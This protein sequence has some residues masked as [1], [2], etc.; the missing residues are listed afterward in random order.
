MPT[1]PRTCPD[2]L[3]V[4]AGSAGS[5]KR[6]Q[7]GTG[8]RVGRWLRRLTASING[9]E[10]SMGHDVPE[11]TDERALLT[12]A[13]DAARHAVV[14]TLVGVPG[15]LLGEPLVSPDSSLLGV[16][17]HLTLLERRWFAHTF[18]GLDLALEDTDGRRHIGWPLDRS[19]TARTVVAEYRAECQRSR[20]IV[21]RARLDQVAARPMPSG[22]PVALRWVVVD[23]IGE[24]NR[25]AGHADVLRHLI[26]GATGASAAP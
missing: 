15:A 5:R 13:L 23:M 14:S 1:M 2:D 18:A 10:V 17:K 12:A 26:D 3:K 16:V 21:E 9:R 20:Q 19:D 11:V 7:G 8:S 6:V 25:H 4:L 22:L 24:T